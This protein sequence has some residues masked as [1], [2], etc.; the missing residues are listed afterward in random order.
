MIE[1][2]KVHSLTNLIKYLFSLIR[3]PLVSIKLEEQFIS[4]I[5]KLIRL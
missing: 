2:I 4:A 1:D 5:L 3:L